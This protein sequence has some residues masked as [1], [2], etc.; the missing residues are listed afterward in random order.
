MD[1]PPQS[2]DLNITEAVEKNRRPLNILQETQRTI[3][4]DS[5]KKL[6]ENLSNRV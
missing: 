5:L 1:W 2:P 4:E 6:Q 3:P